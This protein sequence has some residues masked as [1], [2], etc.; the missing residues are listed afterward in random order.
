M[1]GMWLHDGCEFSNN[2]AGLGGAIYSL[3]GGG[4]ANENDAF[5]PSNVRGWGLGLWCGSYQQCEGVR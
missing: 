3:N 2:L 5:Q 4:S 1:F